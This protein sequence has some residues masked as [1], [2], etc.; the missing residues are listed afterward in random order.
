MNPFRTA[1]IDV[2]SRERDLAKAAS[3]QGI[4]SDNEQLVWVLWKIM[5]G[6]GTDVSTERYFERRIKLVFLPTP[7]FDEGIDVDCLL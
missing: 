3:D 5:K 7:A 6:D 4:I 1:F 2:F